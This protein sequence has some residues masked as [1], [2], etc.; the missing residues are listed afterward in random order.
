MLWIEAR[1]FSLNVCARSW[2]GKRLV[3][4]KSRDS[5]HLLGIITCRTPQPSMRSPELLC[6]HSRTSEIEGASWE[7]TDACACSVRPY[8]PERTY[9]LEHFLPHP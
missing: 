8:D 6:E 2:I 3:P 5:P 1:K 7:I 4:L 9:L